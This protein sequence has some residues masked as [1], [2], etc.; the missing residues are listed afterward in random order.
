MYMCVVL[1]DLV[2][3]FCPDM[4][5]CVYAYVVSGVTSTYIHPM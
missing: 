2:V 1:A 3:L 5:V 4:Y